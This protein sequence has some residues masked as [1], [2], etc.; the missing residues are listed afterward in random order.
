MSCD[1]AGL[2]PTAVLVKASATPHLM[3]RTQC[4][5]LLGSHPKRSSSSPTTGS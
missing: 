2:V 1:V 4:S 5:R 3:G